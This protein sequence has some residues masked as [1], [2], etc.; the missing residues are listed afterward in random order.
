MFFAE[1]SCPS[2]EFNTWIVNEICVSKSNSR[3]M[4]PLRFNLGSTSLSLKWWRFAIKF[5]L[6]A[7]QRRISTPTLNPLNQQSNKYT[8]IPANDRIKLKENNVTP[9]I[10]V[11][12]AQKD[13]NKRPR[14]GLPIYADDK[15]ILYREPTLN[16]P[17]R[18]TRPYKLHNFTQKEIMIVFFLPPKEWKAW[19][20]EMW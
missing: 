9:K 7:G 12:F 14:Q 16:F 13:L 11:Q 15:T 20:V 10:Y 3:N 6:I 5:F 8:I 18:K 19:N 4:Y 1:W 2:F 17:S